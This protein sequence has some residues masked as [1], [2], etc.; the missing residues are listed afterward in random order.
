MDKKTKQLALGVTAGVIL[1]VAII[2]LM[3]SGGGGGVDLGGPVVFQGI[4]L[5]CKELVE[6]R[7]DPA[8]GDTLPAYCPECGETAVYKA[9][10]CLDTNKLFVPRLEPNPEGGPPKMPMIV[11]CPDGEG[12]AELFIPQDPRMDPDA[13]IGFL[14]DWPQ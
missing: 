9:Y 7:Y 8:D 2:Y 5:S 10:Y 11:R 14:P 4:C 6:A 1:V 13:E 12:E 3:S